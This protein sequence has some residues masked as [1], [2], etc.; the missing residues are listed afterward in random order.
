MNKLSIYSPN[1]GSKMELGQYQN[2]GFKQTREM[3][4]QSWSNCMEQGTQIP[5]VIYNQFYNI[6]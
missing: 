2:T 1:L 5:G 3:L 4:K 6:I